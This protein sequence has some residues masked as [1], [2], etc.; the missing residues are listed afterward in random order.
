VI[1]PRSDVLFSIVPNVERQRKSHSRI[2][3]GR[4]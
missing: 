2:A 3:T 4:A 1:R